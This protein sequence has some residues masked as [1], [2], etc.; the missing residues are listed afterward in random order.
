M[1][2]GAIHRLDASVKNCAGFLLKNKNCA[3][4]RPRLKKEKMLEPKQNM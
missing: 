4:V 2:F 3:E 1:L